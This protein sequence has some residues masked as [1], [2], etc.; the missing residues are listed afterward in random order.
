MAAS[1]PTP[2]P[3]LVCVE[4]TTTDHA[5]CGS[6]AVSPQLPPCVASPLPGPLPPL[7]E[8]P[9]VPCLRA[10]SGAATANW[11]QRPIVPMLSDG[12]S[13]QLSLFLRHHTTIYPGVAVYRAFVY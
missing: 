6:T 7:Q 3:R 4:R 8:T 13:S 1:G 5:A 12:G 10:A 2:V 11:Q 9:E